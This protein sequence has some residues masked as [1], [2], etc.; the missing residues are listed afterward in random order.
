[1]TDV[2]KKSI[3]LLA[4]GFAAFYL[5]SQ[6]REAADAIQT[7]WGAVVDAIHQIITFFQALA[8]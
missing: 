5:L 7:A 3:W 6:P 4:A 1:M 8:S 2:I